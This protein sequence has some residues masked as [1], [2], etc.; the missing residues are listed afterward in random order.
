MAVKMTNK[1]HKTDGQNLQVC[2]GYCRPILPLRSILLNSTVNA[3]RVLHRASVLS[4]YFI[5]MAVN[6]GKGK[7]L[8]VNSADAWELTVRRASSVL[9]GM[10]AHPHSSVP[11]LKAMIAGSSLAFGNLFSP[12]HISRVERKTSVSQMVVFPQT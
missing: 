12:E 3:P 7:K 2:Y 10:P 11:D 8:I 9:N 4:T 1:Y 6:V 5:F